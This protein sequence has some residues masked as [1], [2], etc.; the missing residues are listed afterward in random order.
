MSVTVTEQ[1]L[2]LSVEQTALLTGL[3]ART[4]WRLASS[5]EFPKPVQIAGRRATRWK[6]SDVEA[7]VD[8]LQ[9]GASR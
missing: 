7:W 5:G 6:R 4:I 1:P 8:G 3:G 2:L 9:P